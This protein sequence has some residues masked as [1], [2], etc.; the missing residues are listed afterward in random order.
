[1]TDHIRT[2]A[3]AS[4][5]Y[6]LFRA[7]FSDKDPESFSRLYVAQDLESAF[8]MAERTAAENKERVLGIEERGG[9]DGIAFEITKQLEEHDRLA[10]R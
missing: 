6:R 1:M 5:G 7:T 2:W 3:F 9:I 8:R 10:A 4:S